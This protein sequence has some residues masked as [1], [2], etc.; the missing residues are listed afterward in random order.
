MMQFLSALVDGSFLEAAGSEALRIRWGEFWTF[1]L[2]EKS[3]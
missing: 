2:A 3:G 1:D